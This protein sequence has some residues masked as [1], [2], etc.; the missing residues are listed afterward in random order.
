ML[1]ATGISCPVAYDDTGQ[2]FYRSKS[3]I[4]VI[5][6]GVIDHLYNKYAGLLEFTASQFTPERLECF[7]SA[8][9]RKG[10]RRDNTLYRSDTNIQDMSILEPIKVLHTIIALDLLMVLSEAY[11]GLLKNNSLCI[12]AI[13]R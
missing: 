1:T 12:M 4:S 13:L 6:N 11:V 9:F 7:A 2:M 8:V 5:F 3:T 10:I